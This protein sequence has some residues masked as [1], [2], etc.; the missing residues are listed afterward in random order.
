MKLLKRL[1]ISY[2]LSSDERYLK[3]CKRDGLISSIDVVAFEHRMQAMR[4][5]LATLEPRLQG[6]TQ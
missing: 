6:V 3:A 1:W 4:V 2:L 5:D